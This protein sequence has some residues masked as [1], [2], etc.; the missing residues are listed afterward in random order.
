MAGDPPAFTDI[1]L[2]VPLFSMLTPAE[3]AD[4]SA[5]IEEES[6]K[7]GEVLFTEASRPSAMWILGPGTEVHVSTQTP[8]SL[9]PYVVAVLGAGETVGEMAVLTGHRHSSVAV[10]TEGGTA[11]NVDA[12][13]LRRLVR[14]SHPSAL[15][16]LLG[17]C[18]KLSSRFRQTSARIV[19][20]SQQVLR[21][22][23]LPA[24]SRP[25]L[26]DIDAFGPFQ[27]LPPATRE[28]LR[29]VL[30]VVEVESLRPIFG[31]GE[32]CDAAYFLVRGS[33][34]IGRN[35]RTMTQLRPGRGF[36]LVSLMDG[37]RRETSCIADGPARLLRLYKQDFDPLLA[38]GHPFAVQ[39]LEVLVS[40]MVARLRATNLLVI[41][42]TEAHAAAPLPVLEP[43][44][45]ARDELE[46]D[47]HAF[48][49]IS[50]PLSVGLDVD[51][52][53]EWAEPYVETVP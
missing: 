39:L 1:R 34:T 22:P 26:A 43:L 3:L 17:V 41:P 10:V 5:I 8:D 44:F 11:W 27:A 24:G 20:S 31:E 19:S 42:T 4:V 15:K 45:N 50:A 30:S 7:R 18:H 28:L 36:G 33:V 14:R 23:P 35:G 29:D 16:I 13:G 2:S 6:L 47:E 49:A 52:D 48:Q 53:V 9:R 51:L 37:G 21:T 46:L 38:S 25:E 12:V 32:P 40:Q